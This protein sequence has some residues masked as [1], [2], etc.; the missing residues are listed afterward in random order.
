MKRIFYPKE[1]ISQPEALADHLGVP[2]K[3]LLEVASGASCFYR[4]NKPEVKPSGGVRITYSVAEPLKSIQVKIK[5]KLFHEIYF[6]KY[7][8]G[9]IKDVTS[10]RTPHSDALIHVGARFILNEDVSNFFD[11]I[12]SFEVKKMFKRLFNFT[13]EVADI[14]TSLTTLN[15]YLIQGAPTSSYIANSIFWDIEPQLVEDLNKLG[16]EY[17]R[18]V[19]DVTISCKHSF[20]QRDLESVIAK[21]YGMMLKRGI[22]PNRKKQNLQTNKGKLDIHNLTINS[23]QPKLGKAKKKQIRLEVYNCKKMAEQTNRQ[24]QKYKKAYNSVYQ[25]AHRLK[26]YSE[27]VGQRY[28]DELKRIKPIG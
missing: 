27:S 23:G 10:P 28:I 6:P 8:Q 9:S 14:L 20:Q 19:D 13:N 21:I 4:K 2:I 12:S 1:P 15:G 26:K 25:K 3:Q 17:S 18:Y 16:F 24:G 11:S 22:K 7:L 5:E